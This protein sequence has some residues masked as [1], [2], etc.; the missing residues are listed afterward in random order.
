M[1]SDPVFEA[2]N[3]RTMLFERRVVG[4]SFQR[5]FFPPHSRQFGRAV[6][7]DKG[8]EDFFFEARVAG[9][10]PPID[11]KFLNMPR[12]HP[13]FNFRVRRPTDERNALGSHSF[14]ESGER[15]RIRSIRVRYKQ[16]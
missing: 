8:L 12:Q 9:N 3:L 15:V 1:F 4:Q 11:G 7:L 14:L 6:A 5:K 13:G 16:P 10:R 2:L